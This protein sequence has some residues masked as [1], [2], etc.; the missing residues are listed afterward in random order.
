[1][2]R[3][4][5]LSVDLNAAIQSF[6][7]LQPYHVVHDFDLH[8]AGDPTPSVDLAK[9]IHVYRV[10][11]RHAIPHRIATLAGEILQGMRSALDYVAWQLALAK[12]DTPPPM[13]AF[14][15]FLSEKLYSRDK[16][17]S[18]GGIDAAVHPLFDSVQPY[19]SGDRAHEHALW[20]LHRLANDD[21]HR[22]P[23]IVGSLPSGVSV[24]RPV[25]VDLG[26]T[27]TVG[28]F[29]DGQEIAT[30]GI[31]GGADPATSL[32]PRF[33]FGLAFGKDTPAE[34]RHLTN[35]IDRIGKSVGATITEFERFFP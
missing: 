28:P 1:M 23:H 13:T 35:E 3:V 24:S 27:T 12:S 5:E 7:K 19:H 10:E 31:I 18:I 33:T 17:R 6:Y 32:D 29:E 34:G 26:V 4:N 20:V 22:V 2:D 30:I 11:T 15:I 14:P 21:K 8:Y 9:G 16:D 25:G